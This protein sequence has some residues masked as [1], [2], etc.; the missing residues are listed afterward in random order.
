MI[1][2]DLSP[3]AA[4]ARM[5]HGN[6]YPPAQAK[7]ALQSFFRPENLAALREIALRRTAQE[8]DEQ[9]DTYMREI[10]QRRADVDEHVL[11]FVDESPFS[12]TLIR[13]GWRIAQGLHADLLVAY[14]QTRSRG[15]RS[16]RTG[17]HAGA[18]GGS[19]CARHRRWKART[20]A[21]RLPRLCARRA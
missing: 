11:V 7:A 14:L 21:K 16:T 18:G 10:T 15:R 20:R 6:I 8:V 12:R 5:E 17:P 13:R 2:I 3:E 9:L 4:R 19:Q 1:L